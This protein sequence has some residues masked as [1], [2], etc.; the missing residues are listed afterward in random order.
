MSAPT[1][2]SLFRPVIE[3][4][5]SAIWQQWADL[6]G[7]ATGGETRRRLIDPEAL[8]SRRRRWPRANA[9]S[10]K[11]CTCGCASTPTC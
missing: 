1:V 9:A 8:L 7:T 10:R 4:A 6:G 5:V 11:S 2:D 3:A